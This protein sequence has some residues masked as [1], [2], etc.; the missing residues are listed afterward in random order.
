MKNAKYKV[1]SKRQKCAA[2]T[3]IELLV[4]I[5][6]IGILASMILPA[7]AKAKDSGRRMV[8]IN[9]LKQLGLAHTM[10]AMDNREFLPVRAEPPN[11]RWPDQ[12]YSYY[13]KSIR[14]LRCPTDGPFDPSTG[15]KLDNHPGDNAP[16]SFIINGWNDWV[17]EKYGD[18]GVTNYLAGDTTLCRIRTTQFQFPSATIVFGEKKSSSPHYYMDLSE[19]S[20]PEQGNDTTEIEPKRHYTGSD[21]CMIDNSVKLIRNSHVTYPVNMW[22]VSAESREKY[23]LINGY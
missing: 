21:Y 5:A 15:T 6:I 7:L 20:G 3:L 22:A 12:L 19:P 17:K 14:S 9:N 11:D 1:D 16:R 23:K 13:N 2:F 8:C 10:Y 18:T 4:V